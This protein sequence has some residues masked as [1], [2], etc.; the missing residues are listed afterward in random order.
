MFT[1]CIKYLKALD[2]KIMY[3][4]KKFKVTFK[5]VCPFRHALRMKALI[6]I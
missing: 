5:T 6:L 3:L 4:A 1:Q 2:R